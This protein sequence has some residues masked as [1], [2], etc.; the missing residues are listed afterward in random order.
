MERTKEGWL[1]STKGEHKRMVSYV[2]LI[3]TL[4]SLGVITGIANFQHQNI[5]NAGAKKEKFTNRKKN[6]ENDNNHK[7]K[8]RVY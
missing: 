3:D 6:L 1:G 5:E 2:S 8:S 7:K 4:Q